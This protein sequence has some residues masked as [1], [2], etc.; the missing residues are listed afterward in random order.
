MA[1]PGQI[2]S[3]EQVLN[4]EEIVLV[5]SCVKGG[6]G[7][8]WELGNTKT[9]QKLDLLIPQIEMEIKSLRALTLILAHPNIA[10]IEEVCNE[11]LRISKHVGTC[12]QFLCARGL[13]EDFSE[14]RD[15]LQELNNTAFNLWKQ[16]NR[17]QLCKRN[18]FVNNTVYGLFFEMVKTLEDKIHIKKD[19]TDLYMDHISEASKDSVTD[20]KIIA[21]LFSLV[22][23][24]RSP[25][26]ATGDT[27]L[28]KLLGIS[29]KMI[30]CNQFSP[31]NFDFC[32]LLKDPGVKLYFTKDRVKY[33][34]AVDSQREPGRYMNNHDFSISR[35]DKEENDMIKLRFREIWKSIYEQTH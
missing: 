24:G 3:L 13:N 26:V 31:Y 35:I 22:M 14:A 33:E 9:P 5:D 28:I 19:T 25:A 4:K 15:K 27:D 32:S 11:Y 34:L 20:E 16:A 1:N 2:L 6:N 29:S 17:S 18:G 8:Y 23:T 12:I 7:F 10:T 21:C 30:C